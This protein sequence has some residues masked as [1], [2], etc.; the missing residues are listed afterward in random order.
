MQKRIP[1]I[2]AKELSKQY[3]WDR[4]LIIGMDSS[5]GSGCIATYG[6]TKELCKL[7][8]ELG[9]RIG[10]QIFE[11][12]ELK[13]KSTCKHI[14]YDMDGDSCTLNKGRGINSH[15]LLNWEYKCPYFELKENI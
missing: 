2:K 3:N 4:I 9:D 12:G 8:G 15:C 14:T 1:I 7:A 6:A 13:D 5:D 11:N 10:T